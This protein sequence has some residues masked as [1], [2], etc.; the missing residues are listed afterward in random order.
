MNKKMSKGFMRFYILIMIASLF[1][2]PFFGLVSLADDFGPLVPY[3]PIS[4][5]AYDTIPLPADNIESTSAQLNGWYGWGGTLSASV[6]FFYNDAFP[7]GTINITVSG[8]FTNESF[9]KYATGLNASSC[10]Y[11]TVW[12]YNT[13][14][15]YW[16]VSYLNE[17]FLTKP[18][19]PPNNFTVAI[20][21]STN[22]TLTWDNVT[23]WSDYHAGDASFHQDTII[24]YSNTH[25]P[26]DP[27]DGD[28]GYWGPNEIATIEGL[29]LDTQYYFSAWTYISD[30]CSMY[31]DCCWCAQNSSEFSTAIAT[32]QGGQYNF[33][34]RYENR[35]YGPVNLTQWGPHKLIIYYYGQN[36]TSYYG[37]VDYIIF[38]NNATSF[39]DIEEITNPA[40][41]VTV[42][43]TY[44]PIENISDVY[45]YNDSKLEWVLVNPANWTHY[46]PQVV[47][48][49]SDVLSVNTTYAKVVYETMDT[50]YVEHD[51]MAYFDNNNS[52]FSI[53]KITLN[54]NKTIRFVDFHWNDSDVCPNRCNRVIVTELQERDS[55]IFIMTN[56]PVY[57]E[58]TALKNNSL[59]KY[60]Y[61][62]SDE[63][64]MFRLV[65]NPRAYIYT[66]DDEDNKLIIHS[67]FF[68]EELHINPWLIY[69]KRYFIGVSIDDTQYNRERIAVAPAGDNMLPEV[70]IPYELN[71]NYTFFDLI[72]INTSW[73]ADGFKVSYIDTTY[74][75]Q[76]ATINV[77]SYSNGTL[78]YT[79]STTSSTKTFYVPFNTT[80]NYRWDIVAVLD[81]E[82]NIYDGTYYSGSIGAFGTMTPVISN[83]TI[84]TILGIILGPSPMYYDPDALGG[85]P[86]SEEVYV[87]WTY[88]AIFSICF[89]WMTT[90]GRMNSFIGGIGVGVILCGAGAGIS[91]LTILYSSYSWFEGPIL[92]VVGAFVI[93]ISFISGMG[94]SENKN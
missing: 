88:I 85:D 57:G 42:S 50:F 36:L 32:T 41:N 76:L 64:G 52:N 86:D 4:N 69:E 47:N 66:Y 67:E 91:G 14:F 25:Q 33:T 26:S 82:A 55:D 10:Y 9:S 83:T 40:L 22:V 89:I 46:L 2:S 23:D 60:I 17:S 92:A 28:L 58:G 63:T 78:L 34:V 31:D 54:V 6:G 12:C 29:D 13:S 27:T 65:N 19:G 87:P 7:I 37:E 72:D 8:T 38:H 62:F 74:S 81:D 80:G 71:Q 53:G 3:V 45:V 70:R 73:Y 43:L 21:N 68:D 56:L 5:Y 84:D 49:S 20:Q 39:I 35:T 15:P 48:I 93:V 16:F 44:V 61:S 77:Y 79:N 11:F 30:N 51:P 24:R 94:S 75:T 1:A 18:S 59:V 90:L